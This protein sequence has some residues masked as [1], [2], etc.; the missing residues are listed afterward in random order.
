M[1]DII[2]MNIDDLVP[3]QTFL[4]VDAFRRGPARRFL[5]GSPAAPTTQ[6]VER[7]LA[8]AEALDDVPARFRPVTL[9]MLGLALQD[10]DLEF[11]GRPERLVQRYIEAAI[12]QPEIREI[13][14]RVIDKMIT[15]ANTKTPRSVSDLSIETMLDR[16]DVI[17]WVPRQI[18]EVGARVRVAE[19]PPRGHNRPTVLREGRS[20]EYNALFRRYIFA[21]GDT[22]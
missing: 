8:G 4:E 5:E 10:D 9:N 21:T 3:A 19:R 15:D 6:L 16:Q 14:P 22:R 18:L 17:A 11:T 20:N 7:L 2:D 13:A 12:S 1:S